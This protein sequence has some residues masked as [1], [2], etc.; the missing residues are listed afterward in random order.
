MPGFRSNEGW[1]SRI[2]ESIER[3]IMRVSVIG[4][5]YV[6]LVTGVCF[7]EKGHQVT[8]VDV[9]QTKVDAINNGV[10]PIHERGLEDLLKKHVG[11][12]LRASTDLSGAVEQT[13]LSL[14]AVGTPFNG[15]EI[16]L[17]YIKAVSKEIGL[18]IE[19]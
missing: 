1:G 2:S 12:R 6:G 16:D 11:G 5:G 9:D 7:A 14:I 19:G 3:N 18:A 15:R 4:T 8:C 10:A 13:D 17:S